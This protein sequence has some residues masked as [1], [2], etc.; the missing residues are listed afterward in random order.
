MELLPLLGEDEIE[1]GIDSHEVRLPEIDAL[2]LLREEMAL[3][4]GAV[5]NLRGHEQEDGSCIAG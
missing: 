4:A 1:L 5:R 3:V 2:P